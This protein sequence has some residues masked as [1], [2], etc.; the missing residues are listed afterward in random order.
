MTIKL[1]NYKPKIIFNVILIVTHTLV[2]NTINTLNDF[3]LN[4]CSYQCTSTMDFFKLVDFTPKSSQARLLPAII[5]CV[6]W[7][8]TKKKSSSRFVYFHSRRKKTS[9]EDNNTKV[10]FAILQRACDFG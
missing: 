10:G 9:L 5:I 4:I 7:G 1:Y 2:Q 6:A 3:I 8:K